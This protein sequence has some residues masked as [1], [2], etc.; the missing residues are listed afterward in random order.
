M[1]HNDNPEK[2]FKKTISKYS[3]QLTIRLPFIRNCAA[4]VGRFMILSRD[5]QNNDR[6]RTILLHEHGHYLDYK[7]LG[8]F[9]YFLGIALPSVINASRKPEKRRIIGYYNQ[10]WEIQADELANISRNEHT[11]EASNLGKSY[12]KYLI[13]IKRTGWLRFLFKDLPAFINHNFNALI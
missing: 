6:G 5:L 11:N 13:S 3:G 1:T 12:H 9:R 7:K 8:F 2:V 10:P 4:S